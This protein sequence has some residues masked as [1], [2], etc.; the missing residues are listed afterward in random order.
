MGNELGTYQSVNSPVKHRL[1]PNLTKASWG[2]KFRNDITMAPIETSDSSNSFIKNKTG[3]LNNVTPEKII[4]LWKADGP[5]TPRPIGYKI[6]SFEDIQ[7]LF[8]KNFV[9][10]KDN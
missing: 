7:Q 5:N 9:N 2:Y 4:N 6:I 3:W 10:A 8:G 1:F